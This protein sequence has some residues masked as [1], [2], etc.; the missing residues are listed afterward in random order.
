MDVQDKFQPNTVKNLPLVGEAKNT[1]QRITKKLK[2]T[3]AV[4]A[5]LPKLTP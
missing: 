1:V 3:V 5:K 4:R 2:C